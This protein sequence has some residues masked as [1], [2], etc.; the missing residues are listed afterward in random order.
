MSI[1]EFVKHYEQR[2]IEMR[3]IEAIEDYKSRG[4]PKIFIEDCEIL[5]HAARV[6][7]RRIYTRFQHEFLQGTTK[8][9][10]NVETAGEPNKIYNFK[11]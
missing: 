1:T 2:T 9:V 3:D 10:I 8:R 7:T 5:K 11:G 6:Y 4:D